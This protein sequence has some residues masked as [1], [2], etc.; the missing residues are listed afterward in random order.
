[1]TTSKI[2]KGEEGGGKGFRGVHRTI[3]P[4]KK[5]KKNK[6]K[7]KTTKGPPTHLQD[8]PTIGDRTVFAW[9][10]TDRHDDVREAGDGDDVAL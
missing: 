8:H 9:G 4:P 1:V 6:K 10:G 2:A 7:T 3:H 5:K